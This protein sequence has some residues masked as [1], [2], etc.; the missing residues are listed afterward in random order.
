MKKILILTVFAL[1]ANFSFSQ[2]RFL[3]HEGNP[4][5]NGETITLLE[6]DAGMHI[7]LNNNTTPPPTCRIEISEA[8]F[9]DGADLTVCWGGQC[10]G[11]YNQVM[12]ISENYAITNDVMEL[13]YYGPEKF[14]ENATFTLKITN[15]DNPEEVVTL[16]FETAPVSVN[17]IENTV[18]IYPNPTSDFINVNCTN[19]NAEKIS[20]FDINGRKIED[21]NITNSNNMLI[22]LTDYSKGIYILKI[23]KQTQK[24]IVE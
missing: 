22:D 24:F 17:E 15:K 21:I 9:P 7:I 8:N 12:V 19:T 1:I 4:Y 11:G 16:N 3:D 10:A 18:S 23:G 2:I 14:R 5:E 6:G 13:H 20:I